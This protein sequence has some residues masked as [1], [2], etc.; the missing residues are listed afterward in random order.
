MIQRETQRQ[1]QKQGVEITNPLPCQVCCPLSVVMFLPTP[2]SGCLSR[3]KQ[4]QHPH[5]PF[6]D[7]TKH[8]QPGEEWL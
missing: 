3:G 7:L 2:V 6:P 1:A 5:G 4:F 8:V